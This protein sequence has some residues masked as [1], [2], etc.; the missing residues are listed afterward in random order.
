MHNRRYALYLES[1]DIMIIAE[2]EERQEQG[3]SRRQLAYASDDGNEA[4][5]DQR[6]Q[7][8]QLNEEQ[9]TPRQ[10]QVIEHPLAQPIASYATVHGAIVT[11]REMDCGCHCVPPDNR[12]GNARQQGHFYLAYR[13]GVAQI[14]SE[15]TLMFICIGY[16]Y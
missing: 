9:L 14:I 10:Q 15:T 12:G 2:Q 4:Y 3:L 1:F 11:Q 5:V 7:Q 6:Q 13:L 8:Q 16:M